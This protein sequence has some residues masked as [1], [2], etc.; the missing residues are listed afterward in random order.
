MVTL[1]KWLK[2]EVLDYK[3]P[4]NSFDV[5]QVCNSNGW[6]GIEVKKIDIEKAAKFLNRRKF[7]F[8]KIIKFNS[9]FF[10]GDFTWTKVTK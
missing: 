10:H 6:F 7:L 8:Y 5:A 2:N 4:Q 9:W 3:S 1:N